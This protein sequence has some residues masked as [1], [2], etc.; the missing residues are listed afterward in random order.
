MA[1]IIPFGNFDPTIAGSFLSETIN[2]S[3]RP[4]QAKIVQIL[5]YYSKAITTLG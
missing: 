5:T 3:F 2:F 1:L 4:A